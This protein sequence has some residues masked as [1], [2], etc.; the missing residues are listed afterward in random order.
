VAVD[1]LA[2][3]IR[4]AAPSEVKRLGATPPIVAFKV[5]G[6]GRVELATQAEREPRALG[7][8]AFQRETTASA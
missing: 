4:A 7:P 8:Y 6:G 1:R 2:G 3:E 5:D